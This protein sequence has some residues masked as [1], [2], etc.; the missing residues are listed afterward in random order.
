MTTHL[1]NRRLYNREKYKSRVI[2]HNI[3]KFQSF[4]SATTEITGFHENRPK[5]CRNFEP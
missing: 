3:T 2:H 1:L 5:F 4:L